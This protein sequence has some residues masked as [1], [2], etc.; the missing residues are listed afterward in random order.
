MLMYTL[1]GNCYMVEKITTNSK[2]GYSNN[3]RNDSDRVC[4]HG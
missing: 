1:T 3:N 2:A 4:S